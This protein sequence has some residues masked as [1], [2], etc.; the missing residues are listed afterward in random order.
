M[1]ELS[2]ARPIKEGKRLAPESKKGASLFLSVY[3]V[4]VGIVLLFIF[5]VIFA[6]CS[7]MEF[8]FFS[9]AVLRYLSFISRFFSVRWG[10]CAARL[11]LFS[12]L[13]VVFFSFGQCF[14]LC[15]RA[16]FVAYFLSFNVLFPFILYPGRLA[17]FC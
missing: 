14:F 12:R 2:R 15:A 6:C 5:R 7:F 13:S 1:R 11:A 16:L 3:L 17:F 10:R 4:R 8:V 9:C